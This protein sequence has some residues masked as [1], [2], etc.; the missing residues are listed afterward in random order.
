MGRRS[1]DADVDPLVLVSEEIPPRRRRPE[2]ESSARR[3]GASRDKKPPLCYRINREARQGK[4]RPGKR[5]VG[6]AVLPSRRPSGCAAGVQPWKMSLPTGNLSSSKPRVF[7]L[8][9]PRRSIKR[10]KPPGET[11]AGGSGI[12]SSSSHSQRP[13]AAGER[14]DSQGFSVQDHGR[15]A[16]SFDFRRD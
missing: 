2:F 14:V 9:M 1:V 8:A 4:A 5:I 3:E 16:F 7:P 6:Q 11:W 10:P 13:Q 12:P 15:L